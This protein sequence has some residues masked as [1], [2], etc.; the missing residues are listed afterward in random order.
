MKISKYIT[1][2]LNKTVE[3]CEYFALPRKSYVSPPQKI[4]GVCRFER[5][6]QGYVGDGAAKADDKRDLF[7]IKR[8]LVTLA[9][10]T[11]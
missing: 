11:Y 9:K 2:T 4:K 5:F 6:Y 8:D 1:E 3:P 10:E 7:S